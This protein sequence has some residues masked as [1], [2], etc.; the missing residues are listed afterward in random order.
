MKW[1]AALIALAA[2]AY[3]RSASEGVLALRANFI[4]C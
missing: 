3:R 4:S 2:L 1:T